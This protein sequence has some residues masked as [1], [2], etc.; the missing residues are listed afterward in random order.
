MGISKNC[1]KGIMK[2]EQFVLLLLY[3]TTLEFV[4]LRLEKSIDWN[5]WIVISP[6]WTP[7]AVSFTAAVVFM[8]IGME[9]ND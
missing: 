8:I 6:M 5:W 3:L 4:H 7:L 1:K 9:K 2:N